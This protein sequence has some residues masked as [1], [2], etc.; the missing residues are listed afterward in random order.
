MIRRNYLRC[1]S[2]RVPVVG[3]IEGQLRWL[4]ARDSDIRQRPGP[5]GG[6]GAAGWRGQL[7]LSA[8][9]SRTLAP[10]PPIRCGATFAAD[11]EVS[12]I[13]VG[14]TMTAA[15]LTGRRLEQVL[16]LRRDEV[17]AWITLGATN[18][19]AVRDIAR[20][21]A[22][23]ATVPAV[24]QTRTVGLVTLAGA[25]VGALPAVLQCRAPPASS[26]RCS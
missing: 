2:S 4:S 11:K 9:S 22:F 10:L 26:S 6:Q 5:I 20:H 14:G 16:R 3:L 15:T 12:G 19:E 13:V 8:Q 17:E 24:D 7:F 21:A 23:E 25:F 1:S 18:L